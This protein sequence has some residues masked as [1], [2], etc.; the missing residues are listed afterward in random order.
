MGI[1]IDLQDDP[2]SGDQPPDRLSSLLSLL[3]A[4][5]IF[6]AVVVVLLVARQRVQQAALLK[7]T[8]TVAAKAT[9]SPSLAMTPPPGT[10]LPGATQAAPVAPTNTRAAA[11]GVVTT[12]APLPTSQPTSPVQTPATPQLAPPPTAT[13]TPAAV[14]SP[15]AEALQWYFGEGASVSPFRTWYAV[16][17]PG[18]QA[19][20]VTLSLYPETGKAIERTLTV[21]P[22]T[23][24]RVLA[25]DIL[26]KSV[27]GAGVTSDR[28]VYV[29]RMTVG[30]RDGTTSSG[31]KPATTW[32][33]PEG[34][35]DE[36]FT[37]WLLALNPSSTPAALTVSYYPVGGKPVVKTYTAAPTARLTIDVRKD[38]PAGVIGIVVESSQ[39]IVV[40]HSIYFDDQKAAYGGPGLT[41]PSKTWYLGSGNTQVGFT[42]RVAIFNP[43]KEPA[44]VKATLL[45]SKQQAVSDLYSI[46]PMSKDD[47]VL[48]DRADEQLVAVVLESD[49]PVLAQMVTYYLSGGESGP[50]AAYSSP[51][52]AA[53]ARQWYL[54]DMA[55]ES[56]YD[57]YIMIFNPATI[58]ASVSVAYIVQG[59]EQVSKAYDLP[60]S[61]RLTLRASD[62]VKDKLV[63]AASVRA[64]QPV[65]VERVTMFR[66]TV[67]ATSSAGMP[68]Q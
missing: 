50:V 5:L 2:E 4:V 26:P 60:G 8:P 58:P 18:S 64:T 61:G 9:A 33:F 3:L 39:P 22:G 13:V 24:S 25:N 12:T 30:D 51:A 14:S 38:V 41:A 57:S 45:G 68:A 42:A 63:A 6:V 35:T 17:N 10:R 11:T 36:D 52:L 27:F 29:E 48:N 46:E 59:G 67:G 54:A 28:P 19:A 20:K 53:A 43:N 37:T 31:L 44:V 62:E 40:E 32:Y 47:I 1:N 34:Q 21:A 16:F 65:V 7:P 15:A 55:P 56:A 23:Q 49:K 66:T